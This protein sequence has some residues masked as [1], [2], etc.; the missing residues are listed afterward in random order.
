MVIVVNIGMPQQTILL[1][2]TNEGS[3]GVSI[4]RINVNYLKGVISA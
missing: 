1:P 4:G 3:K 2:G